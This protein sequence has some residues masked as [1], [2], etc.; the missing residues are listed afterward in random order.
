MSMSS[1][2]VGAEATVLDTGPAE[3]E[4]AA[5]HPSARLNRLRS[6]DFRMFAVIFVSNTTLFSALDI[7]QWL[8]DRFDMS[9]LPTNM[10][11]AVI[12]TSVGVGL[13]AGARWFGVPDA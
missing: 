4:T 12:A 1:E 11:A 9:S 2:A 8:A 7:A 5:P 10:I 13:T 6:E 3:A